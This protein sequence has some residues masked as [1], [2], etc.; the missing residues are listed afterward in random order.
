MDILQELLL[1]KQMSY[2]EML[3]Q[4]QTIELISPCYFTLCNADTNDDSHIVIRD[5]DKCVET[6]NSKYLV[7]TNKD[8]N[9]TTPNILYSCERE[10]MVDTIIKNELK[11]CKDYRYIISRFNQYPVINEETLYQCVM[12]PGNSILD[13]VIPMI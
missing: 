12:I 4:L 8:P 13:V 7:Q 10:K 5:C 1:E 6:I 2:N 3:Q 11:T 9:K